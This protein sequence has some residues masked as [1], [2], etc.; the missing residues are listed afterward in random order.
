MPLRPWLELISPRFLELPHHI[1]DNDRV[2]P[3]ASSQKAA[4]SLLWFF[5]TI[6]GGKHVY[7]YGKSTGNLHNILRL[8]YYI[9]QSSSCQY[10]DYMVKVMFITFQER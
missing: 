1:A 7:R 9:F 10:A 6:N 4:G 8:L 3:D 5:K 2:Y